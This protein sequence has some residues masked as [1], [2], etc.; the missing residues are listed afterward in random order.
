MVS[1][2][3]QRADWLTMRAPGLSADGVVEA[4]GVTTAKPSTT[5]A[6]KGAIEGTPPQS[7]GAPNGASRI[8][9][10]GSNLIHR[11]GRRGTQRAT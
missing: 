9:C 8:G 3:V 4:G 1:S 5:A 11:R 7:T 6:T 2:P 10:S